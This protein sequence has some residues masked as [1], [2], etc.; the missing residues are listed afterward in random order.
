M[1]AGSTN[2]TPGSSRRINS[3]LGPGG[4]ADAIGTSGAGHLF[5]VSTPE[6]TVNAF[7]DWFKNLFGGEI[8]Y[9]DLISA[10][11]DYDTTRFSWEF[12]STALQSALTQVDPVTN[13]A[14]SP[15]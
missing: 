6:A 9:S 2:K 4:P 14:D 5:P 3:R 1:D 12:K 13:R 15:Y 8:L 10:V 7:R 11:R